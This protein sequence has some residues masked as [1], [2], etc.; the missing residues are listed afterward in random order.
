MSKFLKIFLPALSATGATLTLA[1]VVADQFVVDLPAPLRGAMIQPAQAQDSVEPAIAQ[2][3]TEPA[4]TAPTGGFGLGRLATV[5][6]VAAWDID[7]RPDGQ[8]LPDGSGDV[9]T[10]EE[11]FVENCAMCHGDFGEAVGRWPAL[12]G[13]LNTLERDDPVKTVGSYW[14]YLSTVYDYIN[15]AMPFGH[16]QSLEPDEI[17]AI[18]AYILYVNDLVEDDF[19][20]SRD[21]FLT[22]EMPNSQN[23]YLD[24]R[25]ET[26]LPLFRQSPCMSG[27]K[28]SVEITMHA[29][30]LDVTPDTDEPAAETS[31]STVQ[32]VTAELE[33]AEQEI[34]EPEAITE[35]TSV[36]PGLVTAGE[37]VFRQCSACHKVGPGAANG[38]GPHLNGVVGRAAGAVEGFRYSGAISDAAEAGLVW[39]TEELSAFLADPRGYMNGTRMAFRGVRSDDDIAALIAYLS[40]LAE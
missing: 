17:Y 30:V 26:E 18:T 10:G 11:V 38:V 33:V 3:E 9:W 24:D 34:A 40:T 37:G 39:N 28:E 23:F 27:C 25:A 14:P 13:G 4:L 12:A 1:Y 31:E 36:D 20:L 21:N 15:R 32:E 19:E 35:V 29:S 16:A 8:G 7:I 6:E 2:A 22:V 5:E